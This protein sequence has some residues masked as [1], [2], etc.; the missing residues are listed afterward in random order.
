MFWYLKLTAFLPSA[1]LPV[2]V[3]A[4]EDED[5][6]QHHQRGDHSDPQIVDNHVHVRLAKHLAPPARL[7][8]LFRP[9][10]E[11][12]Q[13]EDHRL[14]ELFGADAAVRRPATGRC[15]VVGDR[16]IANPLEQELN[17]LRASMWRR[18]WALGISKVILFCCRCSAIA[19]G[20]MLLAG[21][22][23]YSAYSSSLAGVVVSGTG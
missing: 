7:L 22:D 17:E 11:V 21:A 20:L 16:D 18:S 14:G 4:E 8:A 13:V 6:R 3:A 2:E 10:P 5:Q 1:E 19:A 9:I 23:M 15:R 12:G